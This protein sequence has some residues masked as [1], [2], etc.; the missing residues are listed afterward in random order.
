MVSYIGR[1]H[2]LKKYFLIG[3]A[4]A[5]I[6]AGTLLYNYH[7]K[8]F[9]PD[10]LNEIVTEAFETDSGLASKMIIEA[11]SY[12]RTKGIEP[13]NEAYKVMFIRT[14]ER[15][16]QQ[17]ELIFHLPEEAK[18]MLKK[19]IQEKYETKIKDYFNKVKEKVKDQGKKV[20][21]IVDDIKDYIL[22][23]NGGE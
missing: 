23:R 1:E 12:L 17:P 3:G 15:M 6:G 7:S 9:R 21:I 10:T 5:T 8:D 22:N 2:N 19:D 14:S 20:K 11:D 4:I 13:S 16:K 18:D